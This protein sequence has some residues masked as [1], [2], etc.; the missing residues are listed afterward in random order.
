[1]S[2]MS[3]VVVVGAG[4]IGLSS[5]IRLGVRDGGRRLPR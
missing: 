5:A 3:D 4:V 1:M 2:T